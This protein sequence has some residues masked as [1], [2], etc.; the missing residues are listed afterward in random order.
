M[1]I[2]TLPDRKRQELF[3]QLSERLTGV[4]PLPAGLISDYLARL[5]EL[6]LQGGVDDMLGRFAGLLQSGEPTDAALSR[7]IL[8]VPELRT[9]AQQVI[10]LWYSSALMEKIDDARPALLFGRPEHHFQAALWT[11]IGAHP[12]ALS[13]GYFGHWHYPPET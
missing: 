9:A 2:S 8:E 12:P 1:N 6:G 7:D 10:V 11:A 5:D 4:A 3:L 13:G